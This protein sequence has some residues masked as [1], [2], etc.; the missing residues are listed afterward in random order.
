MS[1]SAAD[2]GMLF[3]FA[4]D[5]S[6]GTG[7]GYDRLFFD[8]NRDLDLRN[9][10]V[11]QRQAHPPA[12]ATE[13]IHMTPIE[14][15]VV[16]DLLTLRQGEDASNAPPVEMIPRLVLA[17]REPKIYKWMNFV[18]TKVFEGTVRIGG[19]R[20]QARLGNDYAITFGLD[21]PIAALVLSPPGNRDGRA[22]DWWGSDRL[23]ANHKIRGRFFTLT[24]TPAG[25]QVQVRPYE[26]D[27]GTFAVG[28]GKRTL[29]NLS[30]SGSL[31][32][33]NRA[34]PVGD[35]IEHGRPQPARECL[36][37]VGDYLPEIL[38]VRFGRLRIELSQNYHSEGSRMNR[39]ARPSVYGIHIRKDTPFVLDF[40][41]PPEVMFTSPTNGQHIKL[42]DTVM[43]SA[44]LV[45]PVLDTMIRGLVDTTRKQT[46]GPDGKPLGYERDFP[47][48][49]T[50]VVLRAN[51]EKVAEGVMPFG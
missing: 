4:L 51:G 16:F 36:L 7:K 41:S 15:V 27:L 40:A 42:G 39:A 26:G 25:D 14:E 34:V 22:F 47:L 50:V 13:G 18:R 49:P 37:P 8:Q 43:L 24:A 20:F 17:G 30:I 6:G 10:P 19:E 1:P 33:T 23:M 12:K 21:S 38:S 29:T 44:V 28:P 46:V 2:S 48:D 31:D 9:D 45:D 5:E 32:A 35:D 3:Y 11:V